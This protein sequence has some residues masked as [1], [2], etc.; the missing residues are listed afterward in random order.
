MDD[1][2]KT[3]ERLEKELAES[4]KK[5]RDVVQNA[6]SVMLRMDTKGKIAFINNFAL[7]FFDS[8]GRDLGAHQGRKRTTGRKIPDR[9]L[10]GPDRAR[11]Q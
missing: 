9:A 6:N 10:R 5:Y 7:Q 1:D 11:H 3:I 2:K 8:T 4:E